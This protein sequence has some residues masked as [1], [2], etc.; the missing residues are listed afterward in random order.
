MDY[1]N[2]NEKH[3]ARCYLVE[4]C[5]KHNIMAMYDMQN[6]SLLMFDV[7]SKELTTFIDFIA[8]Y[9]DEDKTI[10]TVEQLIDTFI[11][12]VALKRF[13][14]NSDLDKIAQRINDYKPQSEL[15]KDMVVNGFIYVCFL[16]LTGLN[17][18]AENLQK[19]YYTKEKLERLEHMSTYIINKS[20]ALENSLVKKYNDYANSLSGL[21]HGLSAVFAIFITLILCIGL[22]D[23]LLFIPQLTPIIFLLYILS[24]LDLASIFITERIVAF[25]R[26]KLRL[27]RKDY[28]NNEDIYF[29]F[30]YMFH[31][32]SYINS[33]TKA[34]FID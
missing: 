9:Y 15:Y 11:E 20:S 28:C 32:T 24:I 26:K 5:H 7:R 25:K 30:M 16:T 8:L 27:L 2:Y 18:F 22:G 34:L 12:E 31:L 23:I 29:N 6:N 33:Y 1:L 13:P 19:V 14:S 4:Q 3:K 10:K 21:L 17:S